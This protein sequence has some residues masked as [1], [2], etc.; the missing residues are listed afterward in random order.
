MQCAACNG[1]VRA[2]PRFLVVTVVVNCFKTGGRN[3]SAFLHMFPGHWRR[4][5]QS[6]GSHE[7]KMGTDGANRP[8][9]RRRTHL[10][11]LCCAG[12]IHPHDALHAPHRIGF[13][14][15][16]GHHPVTPWCRIQA[17]L[18]HLSGV[19]SVQTGVT[20]RVH[21]HSPSDHTLHCHCSH[22][23]ASQSGC[24]MMVLMRGGGFLEP[25]GGWICEDRAAR[26]S[27]SRLLQ[28]SAKHFLIMTSSLC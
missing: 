8:G 25:G 26:R 7:V 18:V 2:L 3:C 27:A 13:S 22:S 15:Q 4:Q 23:A 14:S 19:R 28:V 10:A 11:C 20:Q 24:W 1:Y 17:L 21:T 16:R 6:G 9:T 5:T 12:H